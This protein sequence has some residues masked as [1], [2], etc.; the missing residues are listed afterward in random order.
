MAPKQT[1]HQQHI[2][3]V[4]L[5]TLRMYGT[6]LE[7]KQMCSILHNMEHY[8]NAPTGGVIVPALSEP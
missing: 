8:Q 7:T 2:P 1:I 3:A 4:L 5:I 6:R